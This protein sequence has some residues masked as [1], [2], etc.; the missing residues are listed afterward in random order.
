MKGTEQLLC[1]TPDH[2]TG[3]SLGWVRLIFK[4]V[5]WF[6]ENLGHL[7]FRR[8]P[9]PLGYWL[10]CALTCGKFSLIL[11]REFHYGGKILVSRADIFLQMHQIAAPSKQH[12]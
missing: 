6:R 5:I 8:Q 11:T 10:F 4:S 3:Q 9:P 7:H 12:L 1:K 2:L